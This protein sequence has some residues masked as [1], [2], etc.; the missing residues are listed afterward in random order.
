MKPHT[1]G[2]KVTKALKPSS[3]CVCVGGGPTAFSTNGAG[4]TGS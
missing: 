3:V 4:S 2:L 1:Y